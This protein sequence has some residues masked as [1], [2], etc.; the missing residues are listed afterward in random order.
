MN[1]EHNHNFAQTE[2]LARVKALA[3]YMTTRHGMQVQWL[4][5]DSFRLSGKYKVVAIDATIAVRDGKIAVLG[6]DP[7]MLW[8]G[9]AKAYITKKIEQYLDPSVTPDTLPRA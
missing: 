9:P 2:A 5:D 4:S 1:I 3:D 7:G 8:R 6:K